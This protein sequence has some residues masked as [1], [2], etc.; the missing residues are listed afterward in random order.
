MENKFVL[1]KDVIE[2][3][4]KGSFE[5]KNLDDDEKKRSVSER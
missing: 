3:C 1:T 5:D 2:E 4:L